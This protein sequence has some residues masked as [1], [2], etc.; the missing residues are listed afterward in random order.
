MRLEVVAYTPAASPQLR[1][2]NATIRKSFFI[3]FSFMES[4][5]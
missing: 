3:A 2:L 1:A 4:S 5:F